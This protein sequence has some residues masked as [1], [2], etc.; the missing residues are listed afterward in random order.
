M[1][2]DN[3]VP[4]RERLRRRFDDAAESYHRARPDYPERLFDDLVS[5]AGLRSGGDL[6]EIGCG[7]GKATLPLARRGLRITCLELAPWQRERLFSAI[8]HRLAQRPGR[9]LRRK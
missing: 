4:D 8:R 2:E 6:L 9:Q 7:T 3:V 5:L 1:S